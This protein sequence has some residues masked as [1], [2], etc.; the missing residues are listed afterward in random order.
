VAVS[1]RP[2]RSVYTDVSH[3]RVVVE[4]HSD[5]N[6]LQHAIVLGPEAQGAE[7]FGRLLAASTHKGFDGPSGTFQLVVKKPARLR[8]QDSLM[9]IWL[10]PEDVWVKIFYVVEGQKFHRMTG[11]VDS[12]QDSEMRVAGGK[13]IETYTIVGRDVGKVFE[14]TELWSNWY[15]YG[16]ENPQHLTAYLDGFFGHAPQ[17]MP[18]PYWIKFY[19]QSWLGNN[20]LAVQQWALPK[21]MGGGSFFDAL[22]LLGL[23]NQGLGSGGFTK[24]ANHIVD[25]LQRG[26]GRLWPFLEANS[27]AVLNEM[28]V[29]LIGSGRTEELHFGLY[30]R[31][32]PFITAVDGR[33]TWNRIRKA[34]LGKADI[35]QRNVSKG[36][37]ASRYNYW[38]LAPDGSEMGMGE[39]ATAQLGRINAA[40]QGQPGGVPIWNLESISKHGV[41]RWDMTSNYLGVV[42]PSSKDNVIWPQL[43]ANWLQRVHDWYSVAPMQLS[44]T[45]TGSRLFPDIFIGSR[46]IETRDEGDVEYY[47]EGVDD[48]WRYGYPGSTTFTVTRGQYVGEDLLAE[49]YK[50]MRSPS[51]PVRLEDCSIAPIEDAIL[52]GCKFTP[53]SGAGLLENAFS[54]GVG[55]SAATADGT[56]LPEGTELEEP[57][58]STVGAGAALHAPSQS[59]PDPSMVPPQGAAAAQADAIAAGNPAAL[60]STPAGRPYTKAA[61]ERGEDPLAGY[62]ADEMNSDPIAG[63]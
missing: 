50:Q 57:G 11:L 35:A 12:I 59:Q 5:Q 25:D 42:D 22:S 39:V 51:L 23:Q 28:W 8:R 21:S 61:M 63:L 60:A 30:L 3:S 38:M 18:P 40:A 43:L 19:L 37:A 6:P 20:G 52:Q 24:G 44:G 54:H 2:G 14:T 1:G 46:L 7:Q 55:M 34:T 4:F 29:D 26:S 45:I 36:G 10:D 56:E 33:T 58:A 48:E 31:E 27:N 53:Q 47:V 9:R 16:S 17:N 49:V 32:R 41:R 62:D 13:R 15:D